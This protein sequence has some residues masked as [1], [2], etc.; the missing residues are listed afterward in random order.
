M[1]VVDV[2]LRVEVPDGVTASDA[3][4]EIVNATDFADNEGRWPYEW[5]QVEVA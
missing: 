3:A 5:G 2:Y 1:K 4:D